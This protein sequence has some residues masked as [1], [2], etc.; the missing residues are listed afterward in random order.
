[1]DRATSNAVD[2][3]AVLPWPPD[4]CESLRT[5]AVFWCRQWNDERLAHECRVRWSGRMVRSLG[6]AYSG[7]GLIRLN[8]GLAQSGCELLLREVL[9]H[10]LAHV[11]VYRQFGHRAQPHGSPWRHCMRLVGYEPRVTIPMESLP[12]S[13]RDFID[14]QRRP[15]RRKR[16]RKRARHFMTESIWARMRSACWPWP[17]A[18][19]TSTNIDPQRYQ[20]V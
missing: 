19:S 5:D 10:E 3:S 13:L 20:F 8:N 16:R 4:L 1:M 15:L 14:A 7:Q 12:A 6:R 18:R 17:A 2:A 9:C 11:A